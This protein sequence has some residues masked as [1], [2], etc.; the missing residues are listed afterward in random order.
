[1]FLL[2]GRKDGVRFHAAT[3][4]AARQSFWVVAVC[5]PLFLLARLLAQ[6]AEAVTGRFLT[7]EIFGFIASWPAY[8]LASLVLCRVVNR[9]TLWPRLIS[10]WNWTN[11]AQ[12][13]LMVGLLVVGLLQPPAWIL[14]GSS[15]VVIGYVLWLQWFAARAALEVDGLQAA[16]F[17]MLDLIVS[18]LLSGVV[19][20]LS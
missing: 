1:M 20:D 4:E 8:A 19:A 9:Q 10:V 14:E 16:A 3:L 2:R 11:L 13:V 15:L 6:P 18:L 17:V 12:Y 5:A 7:A